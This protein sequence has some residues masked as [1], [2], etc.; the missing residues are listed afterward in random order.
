MKEER[1]SSGSPP[2]TLEIRVAGN[3]E[4]NVFRS[5]L[6]FSVG[7]ASTSLFQSSFQCAC[8]LFGL[9]TLP[10]ITLLV[11]FPCSTPR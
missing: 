11:G 9:S 5:G 3:G 4:G 8:R 10:L 1:A 7:Y 2:S 6:D